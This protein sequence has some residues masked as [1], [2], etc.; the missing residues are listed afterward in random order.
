MR[1]PGYR[2]RISHVKLDK[3]EGGMNLTMPQARI[4]ELS[5]R[6]RDAAALLRDAYTAPYDSGLKITWDNHRWVR[7]RLALAALEEMHVEFAEGFDGAGEAVEAGRS[8][9]QLLDRPA[10]VA[11][12]SYPLETKAEK[13]RAPWEVA[14]IRALGEGA[15][16]T[17]LIAK[18]PKPTPKPRI[19]PEE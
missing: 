2:D 8:Y 4:I 12:T 18:A 6:G 10:E 14:R 5:A 19:A 16:A 15:D 13:E 3:D 9:Q 11:P 7:L 1:A 17:G